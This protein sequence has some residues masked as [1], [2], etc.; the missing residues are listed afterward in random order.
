MVMIKN[1]V[2]NLEAIVAQVR[3]DIVWF[4]VVNLGI[5]VDRWVV[6]NY[7]SACISN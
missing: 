5:P 4:M 1:S 7:W 3:R 2:H 6:P